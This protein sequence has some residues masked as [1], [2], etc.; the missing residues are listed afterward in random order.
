MYLR[1]LLITCVLLFAAALTAQTPAERASNRA[2]NR[3]EQR[4]NN[5]L[6]RKVDKAVDG[7]FNAV[8][9]LFKKKNKK[10]NKK[11][12]ESAPTGQPA[13]TGETEDP[14]GFL[15]QMLGGGKEW[16]P[17]TNPQ[18]FSLRMQITE[19]KRNGKEETNEVIL[20]ATTDR[21]AVKIADEEN[22]E[23]SHMILNTQTGV[24]TMINTD[25]NGE[26]TGVAMRL[27]NI[28][29]QVMDKVE[30]NL[31]RYSFERTGETRVIQGMHC[32]KVI[33]TDSQSDLRAESWITKELGFN[34]TDVFSG[35]VRAFGNKAPA[36]GNDQIP[37]EGFPLETT[38]VENG[39]T[40]I[41]RFL[42]VRFGDNYD[43]SL[44]DT[45]GVEITKM[46]GM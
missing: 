42:D 41:T 26:R 14:T 10:K 12:D 44:L 33:M 27:P 2:K 5:N 34:T 7:A 1:T 15:N 13:D 6:D 17:Y 16:E 31:D 38:T 36:L 21:F 9:N 43:R 22:R 37:Y 19:I 35:M 25:D 8:G 39:R 40:S 11:S 24:T 18:T 3:A 32:E 45:E 28:G 30:D 20:G 4:A 29:D 46:P 23:K